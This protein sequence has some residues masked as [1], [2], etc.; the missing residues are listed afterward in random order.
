MKSRSDAESREVQYLTFGAIGDA[1]MATAALKEIVELSPG[2]QASI[3]LRKNVALIAPLCAKYPDIRVID[4]TTVSRLFA[5]LPTL[6]TS[7]LVVQPTLGKQGRLV[8][9]FTKVA[10]MLGGDSVGFW[11]AERRRLYTDVLQFDPASTY[12]DNIRRVLRAAGLATAPDGT[13][14]ILEFEK[15]I[16]FEAIRRPYILIHPFAANETRSLPLPRWNQ[17]LEKISER[18]P[19]MVLVITGSATNAEAAKIVTNGLT[20]TRVVLDAPLLEVAEHIRGAQ[21]YIGVDTGI[22]HLAAVQQKKM[23]LIGNRSNPTWLPTYNKNARILVNTEH[24]TCD[25]KKG[26]D[27]RVTIEGKQYYRC[28]YEITDEEILNAVAVALAEEAAPRGEE[29]PTEK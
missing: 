20:H 13:P 28:M 15:P 27:C 16:G 29:H 25:G 4:A 2:L 5:R 17:L 8:R 14:P 22:S 21:L 26:G 19:A 18:F 23:I 6:R 12:L 24:C 11:G 1:L 7:V 3:V 10:S 9:V